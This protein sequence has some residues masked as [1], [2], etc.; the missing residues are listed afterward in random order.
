M[1]DTG[2][3]VIVESLT[4]ERLVD[5]YEIDMQEH[6]DLVYRV[7]DGYLQADVEDWNRP[8]RTREAW[9]RH[10]EE[11]TQ[12]LEEGGQAW[13]AYTAHHRILGIIILRH[14][15]TDDMDQVAA[16]FVSRGSRRT[17]IARQLLHHL[18]VT[19]SAL[20]VRRLYVSAT[21][22]PS[23]VGFYRSQGFVLADTVHPE[24][25]AREPDDIHMILEL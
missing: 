2:T 14:P 12:I 15:L 18:I 13:G 23:A 20:A 22:S 4:A 5:V 3:P 1:G 19:A 11:W 9:N 16:L 10:I 6:G 21:P 24:L 7:V 17:G 25:F 8:P